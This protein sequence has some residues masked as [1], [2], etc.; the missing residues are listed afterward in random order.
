VSSKPELSTS[1]ATGEAAIAR[2]LFDAIEQGDL[3]AIHDLYAKDIQVWNNVQRTPM[4][5]EQ[6]LKLLKL[7]TQRMK[8]IRYEIVDLRT[9]PGG[10]V[11][12]HVLRGITIAG[13]PIEAHV[14]LILE[15]AEGRISRIHEYL[16]QAAVA[17]VFED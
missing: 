4:T 6:N 8:E 5:R 15:F 11:D 10:C 13:K 2:R 7:F 1:A 16:D 9:F 3:E 12:R 14:C 17:A